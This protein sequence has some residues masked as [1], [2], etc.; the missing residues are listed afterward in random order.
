MKRVQFAHN[1]Q[2]TCSV[3]AGSLKYLPSLGYQFSDFVNVKRKKKQRRIFTAFGLFY[4]YRLLITE[5]L[6]F[7]VS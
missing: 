3:F 4:T 2:K 5:E 7:Q 1:E 6:P